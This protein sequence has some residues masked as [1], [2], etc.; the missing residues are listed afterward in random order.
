MT[1]YKPN[2]R[3]FKTSHKRFRLG[4]DPSNTLSSEPI[5]CYLILMH[6]MLSNIL[7]VFLD[8]LRLIAC[9]L[10]CMSVPYALM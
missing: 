10:H 1:S 5:P 8:S 2:S 3:R 9:Q 6:P 4:P 7:C